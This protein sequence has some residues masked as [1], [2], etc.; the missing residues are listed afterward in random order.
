MIVQDYFCL[1]HLWGAITE[2]ELKIG[3]YAPH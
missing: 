3:T 2:K 1:H